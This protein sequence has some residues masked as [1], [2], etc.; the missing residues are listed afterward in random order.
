MLLL[1]NLSFFCSRLGRSLSGVIV[2][3]IVE[4]GERRS[5]ISV[6]NRVHRFSLRGNGIS[7]IASKTLD[8]PDD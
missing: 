1:N 8:F 3:D 2:I 4:L 5:M 6:A 7:V